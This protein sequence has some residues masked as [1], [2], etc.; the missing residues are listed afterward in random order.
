MPYLL[1]GV[2]IKRP[3]TMEESRSKQFAQHRMLEGSVCRD[4]FGSLKRSWTLKYNKVDPTDYNLILAQYNNYLDTCTTQSWEVTET[5]YPVSLTYVHV[6]FN[7]RGFKIP[8]S[9]YI[10]GVELV[11]TEE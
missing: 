11:L 6:D 3:A 5:N 9:T 7:K 8:G 10:S 2:T 4:Y 1:N